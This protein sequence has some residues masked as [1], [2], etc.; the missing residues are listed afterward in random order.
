MYETQRR[1][2]DYIHHFRDREYQMVQ[3]KLLSVTGT[4]QIVIEAFII[5]DA[6]HFERDDVVIL[7]IRVK[8]LVKLCS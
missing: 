7:T 3:I 4:A 2:N 1:T 6:K 5:V 8:P